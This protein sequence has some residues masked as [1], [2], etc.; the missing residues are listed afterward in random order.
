MQLAFRKVVDF[1]V[2]CSAHFASPEHYFS[3]DSTFANHIR[4]KTIM[5]PLGSE[6]LKNII[7]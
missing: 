2:T 1:L 4:I 7:W 3:S 5:K 6:W